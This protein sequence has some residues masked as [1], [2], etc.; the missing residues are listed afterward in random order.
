MRANSPSE[1][2]E[3]FRQAMARGD[4]EAVLSVYDPQAVF[5]GQSG[6]V[7][8]GAKAL[9]QALAPLAMAKAECSFSIKKVIEARGIALM[10]RVDDCRGR[11]AQGLR[12]RGCPSPSRWCMEVADWRSAHRRSGARTAEPNRLR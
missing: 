1:I 4:L 7:T 11:T 9:Q 5:A 2:C 6:D 10:H 3:I 8:E 12:N